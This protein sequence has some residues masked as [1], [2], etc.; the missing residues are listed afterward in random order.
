M[1]V[2]EVLNAYRDCFSS[3]RILKHVASYRTLPDVSE[4]RCIF[5]GVFDEDTE[6]NQETI[7]DIYLREGLVVIP[8][9]LSIYERNLLT[10]RLLAEYFLKKYNKFFIY[11][12]MYNGHVQDGSGDGGKSSQPEVLPT[13]CFDRCDVLEFVV[14]TL[15]KVKGFIITAEPNAE[16]PSKKGE[17]ANNDGKYQLADGGVRYGELL[18]NSFS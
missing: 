18:R 14:Q 10:D 9:Y 8:L 17:A 12:I 11:L 1:F 15:L 2:S 4:C 7:R 6:F 3:A 16:D 5:I 13:I